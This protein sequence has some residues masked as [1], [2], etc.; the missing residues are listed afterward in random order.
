MIDH[1]H[2]LSLSRQAKALGISR[3]SVYYLTQPVSDTDLA[4]MRRIDE[5]HL[6]YP[7]AGSRMLQGFLVREGFEIGRL[8]VRTLMRRMGIEAIYRRPNTSKPAPGHKICPYLLRNLIVDRPNQ[9][10]AMD[11]TYIPMARGFVYLAAVVDWFS[12]KVLSWRLSITLET[13]FCIEAVEEAIHRYGKPEIFNTDQGSQFTSVGFTSLLVENEIAI[14]MDG[15]AAWRDNVFVERLWRTIKYEE[16]YLRAYA[17]VPEARASLGR[18]ID[19]FYNTKRS[20]LS[21]DRRTPDEAYYS[22][23]PAIPLAA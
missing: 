21:L 15:K 11:I 7:F 6:N 12:R 2:V 4:L 1:S 9:V 20:H 23:L 13:D 8:H 17:N 16:V 5:L 10:W 18:Y 22:A 3:G 19:G 14:S